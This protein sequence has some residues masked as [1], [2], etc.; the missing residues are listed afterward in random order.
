VNEAAALLPKS[1]LLITE[2]R[3]EFD[4][5]RDALN[6]Q[7]RPNGIIEHTWIKAHGTQGSQT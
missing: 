6:R 4:R 2:S 7:I 1:L 3:D 5:I